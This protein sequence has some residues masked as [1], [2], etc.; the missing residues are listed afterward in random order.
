MKYTC[1][2]CGYRMDQHPSCGAICPCCGTEFEVDDD[3]KSHEQLRSEWIAGGCKW[4]SDAIPPHQ[5][6]PQ[7]QLEKLLAGQPLAEADSAREEDKI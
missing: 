2:V 6:D 5:W 4:W 1:P 3:E 7:Y